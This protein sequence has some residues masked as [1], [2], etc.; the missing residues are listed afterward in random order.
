ME[1]NG[2]TFTLHVSPRRLKDPIGFPFVPLILGLTLLAYPTVCFVSWLF[3][4]IWQLE[5][6][7]E[8]LHETIPRATAI[9]LM[10]HITLSV[11]Y[12]VWRT[13]FRST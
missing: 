5:S 9:A 6:L 3:Q 10:V 1:R 8:I 12:A 13:Q 7:D 4:N 11:G 2:D